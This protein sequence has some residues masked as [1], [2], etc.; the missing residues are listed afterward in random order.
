MRFNFYRIFFFCF[1]FFFSALS[2]CQKNTTLNLMPVPEKVVLKTGKFKLDNNFIIAIAGNPDKRIYPYATR[3][4]QRLGKRTT[5]VFKQGYLSP[6]SKTEKPT[7]T[8]QCDSP[9]KVQMNMDESYEL[10]VS[11][12]LILLKSPTDIGALRGMETL[13]Q[14]LSSDTNGYYF[15]CIE[16]YDKPRFPWRG[17]LIDVCR[18]FYPVDMIKRN[19]DAMASVKMNVLHLHLTEDQGFRI[20]CKKFPKLHELGSNG[21]YY[22]QAQIKDIIQYAEERGIRVVPEFDM[23][24]HTMSWFVGYPELASL[25]GP[26]EIG[27]TFGAFDASMDPSK[28]YTY[29]FI[30]AFIKEMTKLFPD[31]YLHIGGDENNGKN[32]DSSATVQKFM[33]KKGIKTNDELQKYFNKQI[34]KILTKNKKKMMG[35]DEIFTPGLPNNIV[36]QSWRGLSYTINAANQGY[37]TILSSG[38]YIDLVKPAKEHYLNDPLPDSI[39]LD[40]SVKKNILGG[41]ATMW[42]ELTTDET[43]DSRIWPRTAAI[44][45]RL[46]SPSSV[47]DVDDMYRRLDIVSVQLEELGIT[48]IKNREMMM[49]RLIQS[50]SIEVL[51][52][53]I[54]AVTPVKGYKRHS[55]RKYTTNTPLTRVVDIAIPDEPIA[56]HFNQ[57]VNQ[58]LQSHNDSLENTIVLQLIT[59]K[60]NYNKMQKLIKKVPALNEIDSVSYNLSVVA[61]IGLDC[62][63]YIENKQKPDEVWVKQQSEVLKDIKKPKAE[64]DIAIIPSIEKMLG[65]LKE[66]K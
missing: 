32:W 11:A 5:I 42:S 21:L 14:L 16:I 17:L 34:L 63:K 46:W 18:H 52:T 9:G 66:N 50:D 19:I 6:G 62:M 61:S 26:Y 13:L 44:A 41:E 25:P 65:Y 57:W 33:K 1:L 24:G 36:I 10:N 48:H 3:M 55:F 2:L 47:K 29:K 28:K 51:K 64:V 39:K 43:V 8:I 38:N 31:E 60:Y 58:Y 27:T 7:F 56:R 59:W 49:R 40:E 53:F 15:P 30:S 37:Q 23:P 45:E 22:S 35:W 12:D 4:L 20:E 54:R